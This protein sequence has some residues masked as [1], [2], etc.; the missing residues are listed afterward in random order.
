MIDSIDT[1]YCFVFLDESFSREI[2]KSMLLQ[3][4]YVARGLFKKNKKVVGV[5]T[6]MKIKPECSYDFY[7]LEQSDWTSDD[8]I[9]M[10]TIQEKNKIFVKPKTKIV[11]ESEYPEE[12]RN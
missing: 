4:C 12:K 7:V 1:T 2:R 9:A 8:Q 5:A 3:V 11:H 10:E 6:E